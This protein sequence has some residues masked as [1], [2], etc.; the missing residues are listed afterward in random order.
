MSSYAH[1]CAAALRNCNSAGNRNGYSNGY[2]DLIYSH[3][4]RIA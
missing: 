2:S 1:R 4:N 3:S